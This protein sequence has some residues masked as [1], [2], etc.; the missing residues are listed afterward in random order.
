MQ[1]LLFLLVVL[2]GLLPT[3]STAQSEKAAEDRPYRYEDTIGAVY[4][5]KDGKTVLY[6]HRGERGGLTLYVKAITQNVPLLPQGIEG[7]PEPEGEILL[8]TIDNEIRLY[9]GSAWLSDGYRTTQIPERTYRFL[10][11]LRRASAS[12]A[13]AM[14]WKRRTQREDAEI[15]AREQELDE[16]EKQQTAARKQADAFKPTR[17]PDAKNTL[18]EDASHSDDPLSG[19]PLAPNSDSALPTNET[20]LPEP[21]T[22]KEQADKPANNL[23]TMT[24]NNAL[25]TLDTPTPEKKP[26]DNKD[27]LPVFWMVFGALLAASYI[28]LRL[29]R[30]HAAKH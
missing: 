13:S 23:P 18:E 25:T 28:A 24:T 11:D 8:F 14:N 7:Y 17:N 1:K 15:M 26:L 21:A 12:P 27:K 4:F 3:F 5:P 30:K 6:R 2:A 9:V 22:K 19:Q 16:W 29:K 20:A 10:T